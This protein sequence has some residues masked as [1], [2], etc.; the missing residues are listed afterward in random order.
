MYCYAKD[1]AELHNIEVES[2]C[3]SRRKKHPTHLSKCVILES[4]G[5]RKP[6]STGDSYT[7]LYFPVLDVFLTELSQCFDQKN[8]DLMHAILAC[9]P[10][11]KIFLNQSILQ[12]LID[13]YDYFT[14]RSSHC[15]NNF[16][17]AS[18][19]RKGS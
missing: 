13:V 17:K 16:S 4:K 19:K 2:I 10:Q 8:L 14:G 6:L 9:H 11:S 1:V 7:S 5:H 15:R 12:P 18:I 3:Q